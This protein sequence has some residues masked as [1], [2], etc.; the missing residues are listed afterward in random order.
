[1][2]LFGKNIVTN[3]AIGGTLCHFFVKFLRG[4]QALEGL[5]EGLDIRI[6][7]EIAALRPKGTK[8]M[9]RPSGPRGPV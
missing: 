8:I 5:Y 2:S 9:G 7:G 3:M 1:M 6:Q 4:P